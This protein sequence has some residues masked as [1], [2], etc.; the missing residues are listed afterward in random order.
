MGI[1]RGYERG[2]R[3]FVSNERLEIRGVLRLDLPQLRT[4]HARGMG[5]L[6]QPRKV[7]I[8]SRVQ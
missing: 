1:A 4:I 7:V 2:T 3:V 6:T 5:N 8:Q